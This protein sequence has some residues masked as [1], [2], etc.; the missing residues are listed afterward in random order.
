A[1]AVLVPA[2]V[3]VA[4]TWLVGSAAA[5]LLVRTRARAAERASLR[6]VRSSR[7]GAMLVGGQVAFAMMLVVGA[8]AVV[9]GY[10]STA[11][12]D[13]GFDTTLT[14]TM[15]LTLPRAG[16]AD[17]AAHARFV[18]RA[19]LAIGAIHGVASAGVVSDL[20]FVGNATSFRVAAAG[21]D[22]SA[23]RL[24]TIRFADPGFFRTL[25]I[26]LESGR[27]FEAADRAD[28]PAVAIL[29]R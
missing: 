4:T 21:E 1:A 7:L 22:E 6:D 13:P 24:T 17:N 14:M 11:A 28:A 15:Q 19:L 5:W 23:S 9:R 25:R 18:D 10:A 8:G 2:P 16:Y 3:A 29:N 12:V 26:P 20:P 27:F